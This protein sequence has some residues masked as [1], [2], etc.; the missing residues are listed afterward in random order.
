[1]RFRRRSRGPE[2]AA[3]RRIQPHDRVSLG[4]QKRGKA[5]AAPDVRIRRDEVPAIAARRDQIELPDM[6]AARYADLVDFAAG[7]EGAV[8]VDVDV[9]GERADSDRGSVGSTG[10][11]G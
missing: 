2:E 7:G 8:G 1:D 9:P 4:E 11:E 6:A 5:A 3:P 10:D